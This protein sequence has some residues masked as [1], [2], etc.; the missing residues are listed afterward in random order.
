[1]KTDKEKTE[2]WFKLALYDLETAVAMLKT[3]RYLYVGFMCHQTIEKSI[4]GFNWF[5]KKTEPLY[6]H[7]LILLSEKSGLEE[8]LDKKQKHLLNLLMPLNIKV[9]YPDDKELLLKSLTYNKCRTILKDTKE[10][11]LWIEK[12]T[13][14]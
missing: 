8:H 7:N 10:L 13:N 6:T 14:Q 5:S 12:L 2:Y 11:F 1:M 4:K 9:R 3:K